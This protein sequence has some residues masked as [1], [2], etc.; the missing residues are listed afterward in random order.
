MKCK[1]DWFDCKHNYLCV[2][3]DRLCD[4]QND[5]RDNSD[6]SPEVCSMN[7]SVSLDTCNTKH[8]FTCE[9]SKECIPLDWKCDFDIDCEDESDED[10]EMCG[11][12][13]AFLN[14]PGSL[15]DLVYD[16][17]LRLP[18]QYLVPVTSEELSIVPP[19][20]YLPLKIVLRLHTVTQTC[21][22]SCSVLPVMCI[23][24]RGSVPRLLR[25]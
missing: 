19:I 18:S 24:N 21:A 6:E 15:G 8:D 11:L 12:Y 1:D 17:A 5:C 22:N 20:L 16:D 14:L 13:R 7:T 2:P 10:P 25:G 3:Q 23:F 9:P 4:K